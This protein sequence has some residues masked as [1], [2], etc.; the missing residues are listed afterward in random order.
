MAGREAKSGLHGRAHDFFDFQGLKI[1]D[2]RN[3]PCLVMGMCVEF[4]PCRMDVD[5]RHCVSSPACLSPLSKY[6][7]AVVFDRLGR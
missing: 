5:L 2:G 7:S 4:A 6:A 3:N 1:L